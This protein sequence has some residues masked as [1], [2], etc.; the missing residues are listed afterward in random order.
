LGSPRTQKQKSKLF[1]EGRCEF[2]E[3]VQL[4]DR[5][6]DPYEAEKR[7]SVGPETR[8]PQLPIKMMCSGEA[9]RTN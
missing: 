3:G 5:A 4:Y 8:N 9:D 2:G 7:A 6:A 1:R